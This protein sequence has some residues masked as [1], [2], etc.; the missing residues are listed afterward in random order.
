MSEIPETQNIIFKPNVSIS[1]E[2]IFY[3]VTQ[4]QCLLISTENFCF[5]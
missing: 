3:Y 4:K 1:K 5:V 2:K